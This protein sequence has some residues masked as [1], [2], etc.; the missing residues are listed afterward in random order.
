MLFTTIQLDEVDSTQDFIIRLAPKEALLVT[1][2][3]QT[4]GRG[5]Q[6]NL[7]LSPPGMGLYMSLAVPTYVLP[8]DF[9]LLSFVDIV[10][11]SISDPQCRIGKKWPND[12]VI[13]SQG[14]LHKLG[15]VIG[16][17]IGHMTYI[18]LG[19][20]VSNSPKITHALPS[21]SL[22]EIGITIDTMKLSEQ[23]LS[24]LLLSNYPTDPIWVWP[25]AGDLV[26][27]N[28]EPAKVVC[29]LQDARLKILKDNIELT[30][31]NGEIRELDLTS[32][33]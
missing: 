20:N 21:I 33:K 16:E 22:D 18:G 10:I 2:R 26:L 29:W 31:S 8:S 13:C 17:T 24:N 30:I 19:I 15:G 27:H 1:A 28:G 25:K 11:A 5:T 6:K 9:K 4:K 32:L 12:L 23:I 14:R 7:W 3:S